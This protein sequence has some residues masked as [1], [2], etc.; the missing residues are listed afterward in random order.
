MKDK[1]EKIK[2]ILGRDIIKNNK[3]FN[4]LEDWDSLA[5]MKFIIS[6]EKE[7]KIKFST[8]EIINIKSIN[9]C[10]KVLKKYA[11]KKK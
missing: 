4:T 3:N 1:I 2:K 9:S 10:I 8:K 11:T 6:L 7:F 5:Q